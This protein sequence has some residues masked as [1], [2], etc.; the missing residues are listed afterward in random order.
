MISIAR[1]AVVA[2][3]AATLLL[4][5]RVLSDPIG[6]YA[7]V[8]RVV[9][10]PDTLS[11]TRI[12]IW[13]VF[14]VATGVVKTESMH[15]PEFNA[16]EPAQRGYM[17]FTLDSSRERPTR[18]EWSDLRQIAGTGEI[19]AFGRRFDGIGR[20]RRAGESPRD[21]D[22]YPVNAGLMRMRNNARP[23]SHGVR[24][25]PL[26]VSPADGGRATAG[27]VRLVARTLADTGVFYVFEIQGPGG[28]REL[29][30]PIRPTPRETSYTPDLDLRDGAEYTW[31]VWVTQDGWAAPAA[32]A[33]FRAGR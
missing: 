9:L 6:I 13:G 17:Y 24:H 10:E 21:P 5:P 31:R 3:I 30:P 1:P 11:P 20:V 27:T 18:A 33:T 22:I 4:T 16:Y 7:V 15:Y 23:G 12:Q 29:S 2:G 8:D 14:A 25:V 26:P 28:T 32:I 19:M